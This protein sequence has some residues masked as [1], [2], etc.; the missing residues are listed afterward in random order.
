VS[1]TSNTAGVEFNG[2]SVIGPVA[3]TGNTGSLPPPDA[4]AVHAGGN[5]VLGPVKIQP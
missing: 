1:L 2:N 5:S 3:I 4:G